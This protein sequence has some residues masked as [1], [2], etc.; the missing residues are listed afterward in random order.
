MYPRDPQSAWKAF[1][2]CF[3]AFE[4]GIKKIEN[5]AILALFTSE[6]SDLWVFWAHGARK[7][8]NIRNEAKYQKFDRQIDAKG[9]FLSPGARI[10]P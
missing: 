4:G 1:A 3:E 10:W 8:K 5:L 9:F 2:R 7:I 6:K